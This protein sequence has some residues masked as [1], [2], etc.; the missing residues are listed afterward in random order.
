MS[1]A[2]DIVATIADVA[3][4]AAVSMST[5]SHVL[6]NTRNVAPETARR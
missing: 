1:S 4:A 2:K 5:V 6:N 3:K